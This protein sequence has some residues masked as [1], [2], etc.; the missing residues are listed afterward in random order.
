MRASDDKRKITT[1]V[2]ATSK[3]ILG[4][5]ALQLECIA[6]LSHMQISSKE[7]LKF[8]ES[9]STILRAHMNGLKRRDKKAVKAG[10][11]K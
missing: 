11:A 8:Q 10:K 5:P 3:A 1:E 7:Q 6:K 9:Y 4:A 2:R